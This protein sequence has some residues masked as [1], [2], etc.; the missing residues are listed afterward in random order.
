[1]RSRWPWPARPIGP[2]TT[3]E[4][5]APRVTASLREAS[6]EL[7]TFYRFPPS[8]WKALR[9]TNAIE[10]LHGEF[11]R[12]VKTQGALP[13]AQVDELLLFALLL[14][15]FHRTRATTWQAD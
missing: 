15:G 10:H 9:T 8:Q 5:R 6:D 13:T 4:K 12:R 14:T 3:R 2:L 11:G 7:L 1:M